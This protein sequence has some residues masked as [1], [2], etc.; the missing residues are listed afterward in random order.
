MKDKITTAAEVLNSAEETKKEI[1]GRSLGSRTRTKEETVSNDGELVKLGEFIGESHNFKDSITIAPQRKR[2]LLTTDD[3]E[4][5]VSIPCNAVNYLSLVYKK[6]EILAMILKISDSTLSIVKDIVIK[7]DSIIVI[8]NKLEL[9]K[10]RKDL[11]LFD[12]SL[13]SITRHLKEDAIPS[14]LMDLTVNGTLDS[15]GEEFALEIGI[16]KFIK[17]IIAP[18][19]VLLVE[20]KDENLVLKRWALGKHEVR[21]EVMAVCFLISPSN[22]KVVFKKKNF[23]GLQATLPHDEFAEAFK[24]AF[25]KQDKTAKVVFKRISNVLNNIPKASSTAKYVLKGKDSS[26]E[27]TC[28]PLIEFNRNDYEVPSAEESS[29]WFLKSLANACNTTRQ[30]NESEVRRCFKDLVNESVVIF[31]AEGE[32]KSFLLPDIYKVTQMAMLGHIDSS[33]KTSVRVNDSLISMTLHI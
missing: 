30:I 5:K 25:E 18:K 14:E 22:N 15:Y 26:A 27:I 16:P 3:S 10:E 32:Y 31:G 29:D 17:T 1:G 4:E 19:L 28:V 21:N 33:F 2:L 13:N 12:Q 23:V 8:L 24:K 6:E 7:D 11:N 20:D 9:L